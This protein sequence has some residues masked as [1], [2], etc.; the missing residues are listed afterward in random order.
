MIVLRL[1]LGDSAHA[2]S[3]ADVQST[4]STAT[5]CGD[6]AQHADAGEVSSQDGSLQPD[7]CGQSA[8]ECPCFH[9]PCF[10]DHVLKLTP[11]GERD[12]HAHLASPRVEH[13]RLTTL[14]RPPA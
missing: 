3:H 1:A 14:L 4:E 8:C 13:D 9:A 10:L 11:P 5:D 12:V 7:C 6:H 2:M